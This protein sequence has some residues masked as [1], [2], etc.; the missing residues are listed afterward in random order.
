LFTICVQP[1]EVQDH[2]GDVG[3]ALV[4]HRHA[5]LELLAR[6][7]DARIRLDRDDQLRGRRRRRDESA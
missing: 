5:H 2:P 6:H 7:G 3:H 4:R 1:G